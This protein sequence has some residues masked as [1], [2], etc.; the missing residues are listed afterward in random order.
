MR[1][2]RVRPA[3]VDEH[4]RDDSTR[5]GLDR[6]FLTA[7]QADAGDTDAA[8]GREA[9]SA[10]SGGQ[11]D[12]SD[13]RANLWLWR[14]SWAGWSPARACHRVRRLALPHQDLNNASSLMDWAVAV[15]RLVYLS[16]SLRSSISH[17]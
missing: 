10:L 1:T 11:V 7:V 4:G 17:A 13:G 8:A 14:A 2:R 12:R 6:C 16:G 9:V 3:S 5:N 15:Y